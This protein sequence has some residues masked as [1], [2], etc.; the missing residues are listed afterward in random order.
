M[1]HMKILIFSGTLIFYKY[2]LKEDRMSIHT[3]N[4]YGLNCENPIRCQAPVET[5]RFMRNSY[6]H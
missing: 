4:I 1:N 2:F 6:S 5:I 3:I